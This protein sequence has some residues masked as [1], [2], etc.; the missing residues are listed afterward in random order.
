MMRAVAIA[1]ISSCGANAIPSKNATTTTVPAVASTTEKKLLHFATCEHFTCP[2]GW[3][4]RKHAVR[5]PASTCEQSA[6]CEEDVSPRDSPCTTVTTTPAT[7]CKTFTCPNGFEK[8]NGDVWCFQGECSKATCCSAVVTTVTTTPAPTCAA[9]SCPDGWKSK[10]D[11]VTCTDGPCD[12]SLCCT[13]LATTV[14]TTPPSKT[15]PSDPCAPSVVGRKYEAKETFLSRATHE[16]EQESSALPAW[17]LPL[18]GVAAMFSLG[19]A[20]TVANRRSQ[21]STRQFQAVNPILDEA[22]FLSDD[23]PVD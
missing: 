2:Q 21:R 10:G 20:V 1:L 23:A 13:V 22:C 8:T 16:H 6:C 12:K 17:T 19:T 3:R 15:T 18:L 5:C 14:T 11:A 4:K 9:F 7:T